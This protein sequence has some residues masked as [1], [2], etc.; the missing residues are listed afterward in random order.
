MP[1]DRLNSEPR[2]KPATSNQQPATSNQQPATSNQ[3]PA[4]SNQKGVPTAGGSYQQPERAT[5]RRWVIPATSERLSAIE[6]GAAHLLVV[7]R[8]L[9]QPVVAVDHAAAAQRDQRH[10]LLIA[11]LEAHRQPRR[12]VETHAVG[13]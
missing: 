7:E 1:T 8:A 13:G 5:H 6:R 11:G 4:T 9:H 2:F 10:L 12:D 3:Q